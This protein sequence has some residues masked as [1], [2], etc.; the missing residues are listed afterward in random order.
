[1]TRYRFLLLLLPLWTL[2]ASAQMLTRSLVIASGGSTAMTST[3]HLQATVGQPFIGTSTTSTHTLEAGFWHTFTTATSVVDT[4]TEEEHDAAPEDY[5]LDQNYPNPFNPQTTIR[6]TLAQS[7]R[8]SLTIYDLL[9][10]RVALLVDA[11]QAAGTH[12][13]VFDA[14][15]LPSGMY[16]YRLQAGNHVETRRMTLLK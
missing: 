13:A 3:V 6:Y 5:R 8:V 12:D 2:P 16:L 11:T 4:A 14:S 9:G 15:G 10:R 7:D 1:M